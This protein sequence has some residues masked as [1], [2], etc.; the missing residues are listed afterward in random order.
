MDPSATSLPIDLPLFSSRIVCA[1]FP[2]LSAEIRTTAQ[3][4]E[5]LTFHALPCPCCNTCCA[6]QIH[7]LAVAR[8]A[9]KPTVLSWTGAHWT[10]RSRGS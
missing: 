10:S 1:R 3:Q 8:G 7:E 9:G 5:D 4:L 6:P 2:V